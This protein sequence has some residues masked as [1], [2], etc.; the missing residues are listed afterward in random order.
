VNPSKPI[1]SFLD[2]A[3]A[4]KRAE[5]EGWDIKEDAGRGWRR[6]VASPAPKQIIEIE[7]IRELVRKGFVVIAVGGGGIPVVRDKDGKLHGV[8]AV[9]DKDLASAMLAR[10]LK[11]DAFVISTAV[12]RVCLDYRKPTQQELSHLTLKRAEQLLA[13]GQFP[14][15][16]MGPKIQAVIE[17]LKGGGKEAFITSP[18]HLADALEGTHGTRITR[19]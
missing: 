17:F 12:D 10:D 18:I 13:E 6:V 1:G 3:T 5:A 16:S 14:G 8:A 9:I 19:T 4:R 7:A 11:A 2:E 15:G